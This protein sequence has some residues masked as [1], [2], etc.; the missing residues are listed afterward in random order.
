MTQLQTIGALLIQGAIFMAFITWQAWHHAR[1][2]RD[3]YN[4]IMAKDFP[5]FV[6]MTKPRPEKSN[7]SHNFIKRN[8]ERYERQLGEE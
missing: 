6:S 7:R 1:E 5:E 8:L 4:R 2:R 3:L